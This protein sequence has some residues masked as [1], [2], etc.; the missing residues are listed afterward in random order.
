MATA[1]DDSS[2]FPSGRVPYYAARMKPTFRSLCAALCLATAATA[3]QCLA[4][5]TL[6]G[7]GPSFTGPIG[8]EIYSL[9][10]SFGKDVPG[11]IKKVQNFGF[12]YLEI[13]SP[14]GGLTMEKYAGLLKD[15][16]LKP[17]SIHLQ[18]DQWR[19][20]PEGS[21]RQA[22]ELGLEFAG[23]PWIPHTGAFT[24]K[25]CLEAAR[26]FNNAAKALKK[27]GIKF[28][29]HPH[30]YEFVPRGDGTLFDLLME[31]TDKDVFYQMD[32]FW[33]AFPGQDPVKLLKKY[34]KRWQL[35]HLKDLK[36]GVATGSLNPETD[37]RNDVAI[38][39]GQIDWKGVL[40]ESKKI[41]IKYYFI[42]DE[43]PEVES[44]IPV[45]MRFLEQIR[46]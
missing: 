7:T 20:D 11:S 12:K 9:R 10:D 23:C 26:V 34:G 8:L 43:S 30:G 28:F 21:A 45:S 6:P 16:G 32:V 33:I 39:T 35:M 17:V 25:D 40:K 44:Q 15:A 14:Y 42:E 22:R 36:N 46:W 24:E 31:K 27:H 2:G 37:L 29:Y 41:G 5:E 19:N 4:A 1:E 18:F 3:I 38:G 13:G